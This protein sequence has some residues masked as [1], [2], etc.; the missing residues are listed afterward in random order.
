[1]K[2]LGAGVAGTRPPPFA[3][4]S[5][6]GASVGA[7]EKDFAIALDSAT[8]APGEITFNVSNT[9]PSVHEFVV[10]KTELPEGKLPVKDNIVDEEATGVTHIDEVEDVQVGTPQDLTVDLQPGNYVVICNLPAHYGLGM[11]AGFSVS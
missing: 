1:M 3:F 11:H 10:F 5:S 4:P 6:R 9:G 7:V 2:W 8:G